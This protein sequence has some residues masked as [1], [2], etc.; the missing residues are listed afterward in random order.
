MF[1]ICLK[2]CR[3]RPHTAGC[4]IAAGKFHL[5]IFQRRRFSFDN[6]NFVNRGNNFCLDFIKKLIKHL[7]RFF[8]VFNQRIPLSIAAQA[9]SLP[10]MLHRFQMFHPKN[11]N[12]SQANRFFN[13][14]HR[15]AFH[16]FFFNF[17]HSQS[18][19]LRIFNYFFPRLFIGYGRIFNFI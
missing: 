18:Q 1:S 15:F 9:D 14:S 7:I 5:L 4:F 13:R 12:R 8:F 3:L 11:I 16:L 2:I 17:I 6:I 10:N 19:I